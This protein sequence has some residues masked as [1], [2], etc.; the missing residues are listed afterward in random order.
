MSFETV[1]P[2]T[3]LKANDKFQIVYQSRVP[4][5]NIIG[6]LDVP[7]L[8]I[9]RR[10]C[11]EQNVEHTLRIESVQIVAEDNVVICTGIM[12]TDHVAIWIIAGA[13]AAAV[14]FLALLF[15]VREFRKWGAEAPAQA[16]IGG[17]VLLLL[18]G[19]AVFF[20]FPFRKGG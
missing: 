7:T 6:E 12:E 8:P 1:G 14:P 10:F 16:A 15:T 19:A 13:I 20:L 2:G 5:P 17:L 9:F 11:D 4:I 18:L 3:V